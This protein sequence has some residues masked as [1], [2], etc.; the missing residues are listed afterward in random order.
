VERK[1]RKGTQRKSEHKPNEK[2]NRQVA[3]PATMAYPWV[4]PLIFAPISF[5]NSFAYLCAADTALA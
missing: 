4:F 5:L 1:G 3:R 2:K